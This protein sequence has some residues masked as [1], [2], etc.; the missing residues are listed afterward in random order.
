[1]NFEIAFDKNDRVVL[2]PCDRRH[3]FE[4]L[5]RLFKM[6]SFDGDASERI[7]NNLIFCARFAEL[8][9]KFLILSDGQ[10][11]KADDHRGFRIL[12]ATQ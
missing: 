12:Q 3:A 6:R 2:G 1:M 9:A 4:V 5:G 10:L 8:I 11:V 7:F